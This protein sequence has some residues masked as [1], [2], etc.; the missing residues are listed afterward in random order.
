MHT[1]TQASRVCIS[2]FH[3]HNTPSNP[4]DS[5]YAPDWALLFQHPGK[6]WSIVYAFTESEFYAEDYNAA[7]FVVSKRPSSGSLFWENV[8]VSRHFWL[9]RDEA[10]KLGGGKEDMGSP[11]TR[12]IGRI[13]LKGNTVRRHVGAE[14]TLLVQMKTEK[15]RGEVLRAICN[16]HISEEDLQHI[17]GRVAALPFD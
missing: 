10:E 16:L 5:H 1:K 13:G 4:P 6:P 3:I 15:E 17:Q 11:A 7:N 14:S 12:Y 2:H 8:V 9:T